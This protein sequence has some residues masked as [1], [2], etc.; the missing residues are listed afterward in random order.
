MDFFQDRQKIYL[1]D[2]KAWAEALNKMAG[3]D[4]FV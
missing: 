3:V 4:Y 2:E 1:V